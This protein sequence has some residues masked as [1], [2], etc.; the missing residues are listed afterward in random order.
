MTCYIKSAAVILQSM[1]N[2]TKST[3]LALMRDVIVFVPAT[4]II[5][6]LTR[7]I[8]SMLWAAIIADVIS[9]IIAFIFVSGEIHKYEDM[10]NKRAA[11]E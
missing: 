11:N 3:I 7:N 10:I 8:V 5:G 4:L 9:A 1:G 6:T 2:S